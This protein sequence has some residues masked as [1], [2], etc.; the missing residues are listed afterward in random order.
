MDKEVRPL[1]IERYPSVLNPTYLA[2]CDH[3]HGA[4]REGRLRSG[5]KPYAWL[6]PEQP[7]SKVYGSLTT[8]MPWP[9]PVLDP[10]GLRSFL[11][12]YRMQVDRE[13]RGKPVLVLEP[14]YWSPR[15]RAEV[16]SVF[17]DVFHVPA[18]CFFSAE[19][20]ACYSAGLASGMVFDFGRNGST[21][22]P[23]IDGI[24]MRSQ[25]SQSPIG[26][27]VLS[28]LLYA[29]VSAMLYRAGK[30]WSCLDRS[31]P[32]GRSI[33]NA[34]C[35]FRQ[36]YVA[37]AIEEMTAWAAT[38]RPPEEYH[39]SLRIRR[40][41]T[42]PKNMEDGL[43]GLPDTFY[44]AYDQARAEGGGG[45]PSATQKQEGYVLPDGTVVDVS[46]RCDFLL[47][48]LFDP[49]HIRGVVP[50][51]F[52]NP[53]TPLYSIQYSA[54]RSIMGY[55]SDVQLELMSN[56]VAVGGLAVMPGLATRLEEELSA[57]CPPYVEAQVVNKGPLEAGNSFRYASWAGGSAVAATPIIDYLWV[58]RSE[59]EEYGPSL[60][61][62][63][64]L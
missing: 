33:Y 19:V 53:S 29:P 3:S 27:R 37:K 35:T 28:E 52:R 2:L 47:S 15:E 46:V 20:A 59:F 51:F 17:L 26:G 54:Y 30:S 32:K 14:Y 5:E 36:Y 21:V 63:R 56:V 8:T 41:S 34:T 43:K 31:L 7:R 60:L 11:D 39:S 13:F 23:V 24:V 49:L 18:L 48:G 62:R 58:S 42:V 12:Y 38:R 9:R 64:H 1:F 16:A 55:T 25:A 40:L 10:E 50:R 44:T 45:G 22:A 4:G 6:D 61:E 57:I